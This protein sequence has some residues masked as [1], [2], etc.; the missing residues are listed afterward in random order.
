MSQVADLPQVCQANSFQLH[1][2]DERVLRPSSNGFMPQ[3]C[4]S[5]TLSPPR[6]SREQS[7]HRPFLRTQYRLS[8]NRVVLRL[9]HCGGTALRRASHVAGTHPPVSTAAAVSTRSYASAPPP[10]AAAERG[11]SDSSVSPLVSS[12]ACSAGDNAPRAGELL[13]DDANAADIPGI[14]GHDPDVPLNGLSRSVF[15]ATEAVASSGLSDLGNP[16]MVDAGMTWNDTLVQPAVTFISTMH[17]ATGLPWWA[18]IVAATLTVR[19][20]I[21]PVS[22]YTMKN[23]AKMAA[24]QDDLKVMREDIMVAVRSGNRTLAGEKQEAQRNF[25]RAAGISPGKVFLGPLLQFPFFISFFVGIRRMSQT[26]PDFAYGGALWFTDLA[27]KD[28]FYML[29]ILAGMTLA[30]MTE[31][32]GDTGAKMTPQMKSIMRGF[33]V[34]SVPMTAWFPAAVFCYWI[35][36]NLFS[37]ALSGTMRSPRLKRAFGLTPDPASIPGTKAAAEALRAHGVM[38]KQVSP[39]EAAS[40]YIKNTSSISASLASRISKPTLYKSRKAA[41][42]AVQKVQ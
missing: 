8:M 35:P 28:P 13:R 21:L 1:V 25:M 34:V 23:A 12:P 10:D 19:T 37:A 11:P 39:A 14:I 27:S 6:L 4:T 32:G 33:A 18:T 24:I 30:A 15:D 41:R 17:D 36:N 38:P 7:R 29:P 20:L 42:Q 5:V 22:L 26:N 2:T 9:V 31:L 16:E 40:T 3:I